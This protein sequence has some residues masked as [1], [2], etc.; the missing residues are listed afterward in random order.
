MIPLTLFLLG[1]AAVYV[2]TIETAFSSLM[3]LSLRLMAERGRDDR[4]GYY[5]D[6]PIQLFVPARLLLGLMFSL[7]TVL[8]AVLTGRSGISLASIATLLASVAVYI[9]VCEHVLPS[10]IVRRNPE[11]VLLVL[12]PPFSVIAHLISPVSGGLVRLLTSG[13][14]ERTVTPQEQADEDQGDVAHAYLEAG[15]EHGLIE[16][17]ERRLLQS[18]VDF[19]GTLAREV[20]TPRPDIVAIQ[21][22]A[23]VGQLRALFREQ[24]YSRFPVY[25]EN[26]D[27]ILGVIRVKDLLQLDATGSEQ[28]GLA[29]LIRPATFVPETKRVPELLKEFQRK[30]V[31]MAIVVDEYGGTAGLV[32]IEDLLEEIV[33]EIRDEDDVES[34]PIV[35]EGSGSFVFSAKVSFDD[36]RDRLDL[37]IES[38]GFET[39]GGFILSR[40]GRV[41][42]VGETLDVDG[43]WVEVLEAERRRIHK[44]R[45][46]KPV[47]IP[48]P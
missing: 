43:L 3:K 24:E 16:R 28:Q 20:M 15:E 23:T 8:L 11:R 41:P 30:Q 31:Q 6:D 36:L 7:A 18:I 26:L 46:R 42:A 47:S 19:G 29:P 14:T 48:N 1:V 5:L 45:I 27:N 35:D 10:I 21:D 34:E 32:T 2:G 25:R 13:R 44:V 17:D 4:L 38:E 37:E 22:S 33:G 40:V 12:L 39:V 9:I